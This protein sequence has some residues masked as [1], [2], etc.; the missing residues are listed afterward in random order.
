MSK[1]NPYGTEEFVKLRQVFGLHRFKLYRD[2]VDETVESVWLRQVF[3][4]LRVRFRQV[5]VSA[6]RGDVNY[7]WILKK[8]KILSGDYKL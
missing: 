3:S 4:L 6:S 1:P 7:M 8:F 5:S 2:L